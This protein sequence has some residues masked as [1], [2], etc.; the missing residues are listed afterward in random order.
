[1]S[2]RRLLR[3]TVPEAVLEGVA[4]ETCERRGAPFDSVRLLE[5]DNWL[6]TP[7]VVNDRWF[8]KV[9]SERNTLIQGLFTT[10]RNLGAFASGTE[11]FFQRFDSPV[12]MAEHELAATREMARLGVNV[13]EPLEAFEYENYG[14]VVLEFLHEFAALDALDRA[15]VTQFAPEL[16]ESLARMHEAGLAHGDLRGENVLVAE[17]ELY[18]VDAT[19]VDEAALE[20]ARAYDL[21]CA[22][23]ALEPLVGASVAIEA[24]Q[25]HHPPE[26]LVASERYLDF[27]TL[28][29]DHSCDT[30][31]LRGEIDKIAR[32]SAD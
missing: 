19:N 2:V 27:V 9:V 26:M 25:R 12:E 6:S 14:V 24:A 23:A 18:F 29:P 11:A 17:G 21:A 13:P 7:A 20:D 5:A 32:T 15:T 22:L 8:V 28:R 1:M 16:F 31:T 3:G 10:S 30:R 4:R